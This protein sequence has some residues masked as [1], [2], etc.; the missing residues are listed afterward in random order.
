[1]TSGGPGAAGAAVVPEA[2]DPEARTVPAGGEPGPRDPVRGIGPGERRRPEAPGGGPERDPD[3][4]RQNG[5]ASTRERLLA[6]A[7]GLFAERGYERATVR[8]IAARAEVNQALLFRYFG[9]KQG[10]FGEVVARDGQEQLR[11]TP[12]EDLVDVVLRAML[13]SPAE[14]EADA[15]RSLETL[16]RSIGGGEVPAAVTELGDDY[17]RVFASLSGSEDRA[18]RADLA[19]SWLLGIGLLRVVVGRRALAD[20]DPD[21]VCHLVTGALRQLLSGGDGSGDHDRGNPGGGA[22]HE[23]DGGD[24]RDGDGGGG[25]HDRDG[26]GDGDGGDGRD[27]GGGR[28]GRGGA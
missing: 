9:S 22:D 20:A 11:G 25:D 4:P 23:R 19:L 28:C 15:G 6:A 8:E 26:D 13:Q 17:A 3:A 21:R 2:P 10:L 5:A 12:P 1:M 16:L 14:G 27:G 18:L 24:A 7:S